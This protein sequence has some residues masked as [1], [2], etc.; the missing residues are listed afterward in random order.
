MNREAVITVRVTLA[1]VGPWLLNWAIC[2]TIGFP[3]FYSLK[4]Y[5]AGLAIIAIIYA[6]SC[7]S[8]D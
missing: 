7:R 5:V 8:K 1:L 2:S 4:T 6:A 3:P